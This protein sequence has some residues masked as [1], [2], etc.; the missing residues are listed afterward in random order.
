M[1]DT[2]TA[3]DSEEKN[4]FDESKL[5]ECIKFLESQKFASI[6]EVYSNLYILDREEYTYT[7]TWKERLF[8]RP[9][10]PFR[11]TEQRYRDVPGS[12]AM[13]AKLPDGNTVIFIHPLYKHKMEKAIKSVLEERSYGY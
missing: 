5:K 11:K 2:T 13:I 1:D 4:W 10:R 3:S 8:K 12:K 9:W 7:R 6:P